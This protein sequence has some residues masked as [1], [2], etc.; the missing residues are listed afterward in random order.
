[1]LWVSPAPTPPPSL[2]PKVKYKQLNADININLYGKQ[3]MA[4]IEEGIVKC[5]EKESK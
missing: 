2:H 1:M 4:I 3:I 5:R